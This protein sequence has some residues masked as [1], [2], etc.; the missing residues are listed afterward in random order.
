MIRLRDLEMLGVAP[1]FLEK[2]GL[3]SEQFLDDPTIKAQ[4]S[5]SI[6]CSFK[7]PSC[8][9]LPIS[10]E[11]EYLLGIPPIPVGITDP[12]LLKLYYA[13]RQQK[14]RYKLMKLIGFVNPKDT[15]SIGLRVSAFNDHHE[16]LVLATVVAHILLGKAKFNLDSLM[17]YPFLNAKEFEKTSVPKCVNF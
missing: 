6:I 5:E 8:Q 9:P 1:D 17:N 12:L 10:A 2:I 13:I 3:E 11:V 14:Y 15:K 7:T 16:Q 4:Y